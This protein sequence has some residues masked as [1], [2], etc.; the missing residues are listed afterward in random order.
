MSE[1][2]IGAIHMYGFNFAPRGWALCDGQ[3]LPIDQNSALFALLGTI[4]GGD[5]RSTVGLPDLRSRVPIHQ[6]R[7]P[8]LYQ[9]DIGS[10]GGSE[11]ETL[12]VP[13]MPSHNHSATIGPMDFSTVGASLNCNT[14]EAT[15]DAPAGNTLANGNRKT[16]VSDAP[17]DSMNPSSIELSGSATGS[18]SVNDNG[19]S[20]PHNNMQPFLT[21]NFCIALVG[22]FPPRQ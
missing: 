17:N 12:T 15:T 20:Q 6:G 22:L 9:R 2:F 16:Y 3:L 19:G 13:Q 14:A 7:G 1:P 11:I 5:G 4:Y 18:V 8:G 21:I 10:R